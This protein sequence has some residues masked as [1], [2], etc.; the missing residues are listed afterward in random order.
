MNLT[1]PVKE[2]YNINSFEK[3]DNDKQ[4]VIMNAVCYEFAQKGYDLASTNEMV[5]KAK[6]SKGMLFYYFE[7]KQ[8]LYQYLVNESL[9]MLDQM[10]KAMNHDKSDIIAHYRLMAETEMKYYYKHPALFT[11]MG[12]IIKNSNDLLEKETITRMHQ[13]FITF[14]KIKN[15][16]S[17]FDGSLLKEDLDKDKAIKIIQYA[18]EG[19]EASLTKKMMNT[20]LTK[21]D[22]DQE[23]KLFNTFLESLKK[24]FYGG[25]Q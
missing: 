1:L 10:I 3:L 24:I 4:E 12:S 21:A 13:T 23:M 8:K 22:F 2:V 18:I 25:K 14:Q 6:I 19:Y 9:D 11:F 17:T 15:D 20:D 5:S 16:V 7:N